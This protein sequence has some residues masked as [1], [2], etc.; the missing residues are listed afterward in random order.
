MIRAFSGPIGA[1]CLSYS[2]HSD[3]TAAHSISPT[4]VKCALDLEIKL[5]KTHEDV[6]VVCLAGPSA[7][8]AGRA[9]SPGGQVLPY[10]SANEA[11]LTEGETSKRYG[12]AF[13]RIHVLPA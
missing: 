2:K 13:S 7:V 1:A 12:A 5:E 9:E 11:A 10:V 4:A 3:S 6:G 8:G